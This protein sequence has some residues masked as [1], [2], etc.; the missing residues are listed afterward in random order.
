MPEFM[1]RLGRPRLKAEDRREEGMGVGLE[2][3]G[4]E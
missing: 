1:G 2:A 3:F 4:R